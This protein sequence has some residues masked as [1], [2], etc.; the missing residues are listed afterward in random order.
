MQTAGTYEVFIHWPI[1]TDAASI[2]PISIHHMDGMTTRYVNQR[3][4]GGTW[5]SLGTYAFEAGVNGS[6]S[7]IPSADPA[8][9]GEVVA[10]AV[11]LVWRTP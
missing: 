5:V 9:S 8:A 11:R 7:I 1:L 4:D 3:I 6:I 2:V 10:D